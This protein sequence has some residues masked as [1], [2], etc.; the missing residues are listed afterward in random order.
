MLDPERPCWTLNALAG[1]RASRVDACACS[2]CCLHI[3]P[4]SPL[5]LPYVSPRSPQLCCLSACSPVQARERLLDVEALYKEGLVSDEERQA[6]RRRVLDL[7]VQGV[8][9]AA[10]GVGLPGLAAQRARG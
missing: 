4:R 1:P 3:S 7:V 10:K 8:S 2:L 9:P 6:L 5:H